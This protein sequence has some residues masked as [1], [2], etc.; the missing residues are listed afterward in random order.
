[1]KVLILRKCEDCGK[2]M[3]PIMAD[4]F[5]L[6]LLKF[7]GQIVHFIKDSY[8]FTSEL[9]TGV[10]YPPDKFHQIDFQYIEDD[11]FGIPILEEK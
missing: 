10:K 1:M 2:A 9:F 11:K 7:H 4:D 6:G 5:P 8:S 3:I